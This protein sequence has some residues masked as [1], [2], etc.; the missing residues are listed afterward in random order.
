MNDE[1]M[2]LLGPGDTFTEAPGCKHKISDNAS[3]TESATLVAT[4]IVATETVERD[5]IE[6]LVV[7]DEKYREVVA[8]AQAKAKAAKEAGGKV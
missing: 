2:K 5:G 1:P 4:L 3:T 7:I 8:E 6:G